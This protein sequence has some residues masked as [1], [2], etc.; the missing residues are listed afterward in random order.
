MKEDSCSV[1]DAAAA[2]TSTILEKR[3]L[4]IGCG[5]RVHPDWINIDIVALAPNV[6]VHNISEGLPFGD[7]SADAVY[8]S[9]VLEHLRH[10]DAPKFLAEC[11]RILAPGG[12][13]RVV[14]PDLETICRL[15]LKALDSALAGESEAAQ[16]YDWIMLELLDQQVRDYSGGEMGA[17]WK[18][19]PMPAEDFVVARMGGEFLRFREW[20]RSQPAST[21]LPEPAPTVEEA[22]R[23]RQSGEV[24]RWMYDRWSLGQMLRQCGFVDIGVCAFNESRIPDFNRYGLD[25]EP[26]GSIRKPDSLFIEAHKP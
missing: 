1:V 10:S 13:M 2:N 23:F 21:P 7:D 18:R 3:L 20:W 11:F 25:A 5:S 16:R 17:Y 22:I 8:H 19:M 12:V 4:N 24:H 6:I 9:H 26:D 15:Y 14:V